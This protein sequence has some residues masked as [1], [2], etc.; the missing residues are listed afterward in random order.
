MTRRT[1]IVCTIGPASDS[2]ESL[3]ALV[4]AGM[5]VARLNASHAGPAELATRLEGVRAAADRA[6]RH[7]AVMLDLAGPKLRLGEMA[8]GVVLTDG[9]TFELHAQECVGDS[10]Q[11]CISYEG[12]AADIMSGNRLLIDDGH[13]ELEV[14]S[15]AGGKVTTRVVSGGPLTSRK[16]INA[17]GVKLNVEPVTRFDRAMVQWAQAKDVEF[18]AQSFVR[19]AADV[20]KLRDLMGAT[21]IP[22]VAKIETHEAAGAIDT[23]V[24]AA[25]AVMVARGD[26]GVE[27][28]PEA[29]PVLQREIVSQCRSAGK[30]VIVATEMLESMVS[31]RRPTRA[32]ASDVANAVFDLAD[33]V[34]LS[35]ET[36]I[37]AHPALAAETMAR[38]ATKAEEASVFSSRDNRSSGGPNDIAAAVSAAACDLASDLNAAAIISPTESGATARVVATHRPQALVVAVTADGQT[39][40]RLSLVWG[41]A[42]AVSEL[43][44]ETKAM[45]DAAVDIA[46]QREL[47]ETGDKVVITAGVTT[48]TPG[49]TDLVVA[50]RV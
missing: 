12:L 11:A 7:V 40:R 39:A 37:G 28:S 38:I 19:E 41:V 13:I 6:G 8:P 4:E 50:R 14:A 32:E 43:P 21:Q 35:G 15:T 5:D 34:L 42:P 9:A 23:I 47:V 46:K 29:V 33:A 17:P 22:I 16:G 10:R 27:A 18:V 2:P 1:K 25:D 3:D 48:H 24:S 20:L 45:L 44:R 36:A 30:P 49:A 31:A 26:L